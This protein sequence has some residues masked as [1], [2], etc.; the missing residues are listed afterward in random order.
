MDSTW[1]KTLTNAAIIVAIAGPI[2]VL[3]LLWMAD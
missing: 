2:C 3:L 1:D